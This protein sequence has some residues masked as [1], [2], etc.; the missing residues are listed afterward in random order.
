MKILKLWYLVG[1]ACPAV[2]LN[3]LKKVLK[4]NMRR[5]H[6]VSNLN[7]S[8]DCILQIFTWKNLWTSTVTILFTLTSKPIKGTRDR[9][10]VAV[11]V[12]INWEPSPPIGFQVTNKL[13]LDECINVYGQ[14]VRRFVWNVF[15]LMK[16]KGTWDL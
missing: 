7:C 15:S 2:D 3:R 10:E 11:S 9:L 6:P 5:W 8:D 12:Q 13:N 4:H 16:L 14:R 1:E